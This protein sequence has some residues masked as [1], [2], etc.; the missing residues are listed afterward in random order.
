MLDVY[1]LFALGQNSLS[2]FILIPCHLSSSLFLVPCISDL[3]LNNGDQTT[4]DLRL[5]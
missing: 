5:H 2:C 4:S 1:M 3:D